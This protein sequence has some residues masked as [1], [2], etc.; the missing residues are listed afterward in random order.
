[1]SILTSYDYFRDCEIMYKDLSALSDED[2]ELFGVKDA[3][4]RREMITE[5]S[6]QPN[7]AIHFDKFV[8]VNSMVLFLQ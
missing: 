7:Q 8:S 1:M 5:L 2:L 6:S 3:E 4:T